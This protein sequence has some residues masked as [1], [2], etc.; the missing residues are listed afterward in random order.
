MNDKY[1]SKE[2]STAIKG[3]MIF[4]IIL[5]H[6]AVLTTDKNLQFLMPYLYLFHVKIFFIL[7]FLYKVKP[8]PFKTSCIK[9]FI[10]LY[11]PFIILFI[12]LSITYYF[13]TSSVDDPNPIAKSFQDINNNKIT[14]FLSTI[15][16]G[17]IYLIDFYTGYQ[18]LWF[19]PVMFSLNI[20]KNYC[21][22]NK[23]VRIV[24]LLLGIILYCVLFAF[25]VTPDITL[26]RYNILL[27]SPFAITQ[28]IAMYFLGYTCSFIL[29]RDKYHRS[30]TSISSFIFILLSIYII[31]K[32]CINKQ[33]SKENVYSIYQFIIPFFAMGFIYTLRKRI[34][35]I[36]ILKKLGEISLP[37]YIFSSLMC[38]LVFL[39]FKKFDLINLINGIIAQIIIVFISYYFVILLKRIPFIYNKLFPNTL[40]DLRS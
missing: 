3:L 12:L 34:S 25:V 31:Y 32:L 16:T 19:L 10:R 36:A 14:Y 30:I 1:L 40:Q 24:F 23:K 20:I 11:Y 21:Q 37:L 15:F 2:E 33:F 4:F 13:T 29:L 9:N 38:T 35:K 6:N 27:Y 7:P 5:G 22:D 39:I 26:L 8:I 28:G 17:D 18:F